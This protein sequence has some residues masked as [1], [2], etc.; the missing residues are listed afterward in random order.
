VKLKIEQVLLHLCQIY[1]NF[2]KET[3]DN[4]ERV[5]CNSPLQ[6]PF[7]L[8]AAVKPLIF[9]THK[10]DV[11]GLMSGLGLGLGL[12]LHRFFPGFVRFPLRSSRVRLKFKPVPCLRIC[13][14]YCFDS[15]RLL[16]P[17]NNANKTSHGSWD[18][19]G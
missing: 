4:E 13:T 7:F 3:N 19:R 11:S 15:Q 5:D 9:G 6:L 16:Y 14:H 8:Q 17:E 10:I 12:G 1:F 2:D 18:G